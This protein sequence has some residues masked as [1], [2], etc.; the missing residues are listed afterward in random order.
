MNET[1]DR[2]RKKL[3]QIANA[4]KNH[5]TPPIPM[6][7]PAS[8]LSSTA[9]AGAAAS[10]AASAPVAATTELTQT[11]MENVLNPDELKLFQQFQ[12][13]L[14]Q[15][16]SWDAQ[17]IAATFEH[18]HTEAKRNENLHNLCECLQHLQTNPKTETKNSNSNTNGK[19]AHT[20]NQQQQM[21]Q[22]NNN[23]VS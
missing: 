10:V 2:L 13:Q 5:K 11:Q 22:Q 7:T 17:A 6:P 14:P 23:T 3:S 15:P 21:Q 20:N 9:A 16:T 8:T 1:R 19:K 4:R 12:Q 18:I